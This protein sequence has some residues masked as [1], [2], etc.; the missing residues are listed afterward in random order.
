[1][2]PGQLEYEILVRMRALLLL[3]FWW[4]IVQ[5]VSFGII[6]GLLIRVINR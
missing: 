5:A 6:I 1:M 3:L 4:A 2:N